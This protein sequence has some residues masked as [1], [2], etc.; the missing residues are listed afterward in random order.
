MYPRNNFVANVIYTQ[1]ITNPL[2]HNVQPSHGPP[3]SMLKAGLII[4]LRRLFCQYSPLS[5][6]RNEPLKVSGKE[7]GRVFF[8]FYDGIRSFVLAVTVR[9]AERGEGQLIKGVEQLRL[10]PFL[11]ILFSWWNN[12]MLVSFR[13]IM[14]KTRKNFKIIASR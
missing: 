2:L 4:T 12:F 8:Q 10:L 11:A 1:K 5:F 9:L 7:D 14:G 13:C 3:K 6:L